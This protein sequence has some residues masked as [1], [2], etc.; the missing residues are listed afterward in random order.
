MSPMSSREILSVADLIGHA[1]KGFPLRTM[2]KERANSYIPKELAMQLKGDALKSTVPFLVSLVERVKLAQKAYGKE[3]AKQMADRREFAQA[4]I[5][6]IKV[7]MNAMIDDEKTS[8]IKSLISEVE[9]YEKM[10]M[11]PVSMATVDA[12][13]TKAIFMKME[14]IDAGATDP[15]VKEYMSRR[16]CFSESVSSDVEISTLKAMIE[17][18]E[19]ECGN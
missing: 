12:E 19:D 7:L 3:Y 17:M 8:M 16:I 1:L 6:E 18:L 14:G 11:R 15:Y 13:A 10:G 4:R 5:K 9:Y 2:H